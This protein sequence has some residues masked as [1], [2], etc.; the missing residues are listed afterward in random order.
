[1]RIVTLTLAICAALA[2]AAPGFAEAD[3]KPSDTKTEK[4]DEKK[5]DTMPP[6]KADDKE[7]KSSDD[8]EK[9]SK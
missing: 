1:M 8:S 9:S 2:I 6:A 7:E 5:G 4:V 3:E